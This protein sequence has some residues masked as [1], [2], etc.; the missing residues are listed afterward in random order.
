[1][2]GGHLAIKAF[3]GEGLDD[4]VKETRGYFKNVVITKPKSSRSESREVFV[5]AKG[6][7]GVRDAF[8]ELV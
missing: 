6:F 8:S 4:W 2:T 5:V 3:Q 1:M 7:S